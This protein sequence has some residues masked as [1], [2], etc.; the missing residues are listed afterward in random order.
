ML[1]KHLSFCAG[2]I[3]LFFNISVTSF[4]CSALEV[5]EGFEKGYIITMNK[6]TI[7]GFIQNTGKN[8]H[9]SVSFREFID[10]EAN[11]FEP[12]DLLGFYVEP[13]KLYTS[14]A[15]YLNDFLR[16]SGFDISSLKHPDEIKRLLNHFDYLIKFSDIPI[17]PVIQ[18]LGGNAVIVMPLFFRVLFQSD[19]SLLTYDRKLFAHKTDHAVY[20]LEEYEQFVRK[21]Y[22]DYLVKNKEYLKVLLSF[23]SDCMEIRNRVAHTRFDANSI[24]NL[25]IEYNHCKGLKD[26]VA[27]FPSKIEKRYLFSLKSNFHIPTVKANEEKRGFE[28]VERPIL[29]SYSPGFFFEFL[30]V[31]ESFATAVSLGLVYSYVNLNNLIVEENR[32][33]LSIKHD[34]ISVKYHQF[35]IPL[36]YK[37]RIESYSLKPYL[38]FGYSMSFKYISDESYHV[39]TTDVNSNTSTYTL[40]I[41]VYDFKIQHDVFAGIGMERKYKNNLNFFGDIFYSYSNNVVNFF[42]KGNYIHNGV[43][44]S[45]FIDKIN[46]HNIS[47]QL[48]ISYKL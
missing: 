24:I 7:H 35:S 31:R 25:L 33:L 36:A 30:K 29:M 46:L 16:Q 18:S 23:T 14:K 43:H 37:Y 11:T 32:S 42:D 10:E 27:I 2:L 4:T 13:N 5:S 1:K 28:Y 38:S 41:A 44:Y 34:C 45:M 8:L 26:Y 20:I 21:D 19:V 15:L 22:A 9:Y 3:V 12:R 47:L 40:P 17:E 6:D 48:G 39:I